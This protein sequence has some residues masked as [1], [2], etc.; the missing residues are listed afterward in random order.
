MTGPTALKAQGD[1]AYHGK[2]PQMR[3]T[4]TMAQLG[5]GKMEL[6][7]VDGILY[8]NIPKVTPAGKFIRVDPQ[9]KNNPLSK[10][11]GSL[12]EQMNPLNSFAAMKKGVQKVRYVG[13]ET[14]EGTPTDHYVVTVDSAALAK[15]MKQP[16]ATAALPKQLTYNMWLDQQDLLRR[17]RFRVQGLT[18]QMDMTRWGEPVHVSAP[19]QSKVV[20]PSRISG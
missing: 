6:R 14:V 11:F 1:V 3:M 7:F 17:T 5:N 4:M 9:D 13:H 19:P 20:D 16:Q 18:T 15:Q 10:N 12:S 8:L 2:S